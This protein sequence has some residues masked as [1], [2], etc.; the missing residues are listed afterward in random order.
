LLLICSGIDLWHGEGSVRLPA[1]RRSAKVPSGC[2]PIGDRAPLE[3]AL[4][5][6]LSISQR[7]TGFPSPGVCDLVTTTGSFARMPFSRTC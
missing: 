3:S 4:V 7:V 1:D 5:D 2:L 6:V